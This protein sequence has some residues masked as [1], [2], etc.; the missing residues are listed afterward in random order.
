[1]VKD[2]LNCQQ[3]AVSV[4]GK[5]M[6]MEHLRDDKDRG[7]QKYSDENLSLQTVV[8]WPR[9]ETWYPR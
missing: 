7:K 1:M 2:A 5:E 6:S 4:M 9:N 8:H 3:Y